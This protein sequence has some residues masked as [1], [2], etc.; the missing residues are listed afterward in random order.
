MKLKPNSRRLLALACLATLFA[1]VSG[2]FGWQSQVKVA[3]AMDC[4]DID[5]SPGSQYPPDPPPDLG[6]SGGGNDGDPG[7]PP[8]PT[9]P[10]CIPS[11]APP[12][13]SA[14]FALDPAYPITLG[15]DPEDLGVDMN[16][17]LARAGASLC[18]GQP[19]V[20]IVAFSV[21][22]VR[23]AASSIAWITGDLARK[24]PG[25]R[26]KGIYPFTPPFQVSG[27]GTPLARLSF[28]FDPLN[29]GYY[30]VSLLVVQSDG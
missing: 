15:Q 16:G 8:D 18:P 21:T 30:E 2:L 9:Q 7:E 14:A 10:P 12:T 29:P 1:L 20:R 22:E 27:L 5:C 26:V 25:A 17:I 23:L 24:H 13:I 4:V 6:G 11:W 28:H 19:A 3:H